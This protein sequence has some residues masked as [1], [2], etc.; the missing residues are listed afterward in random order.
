MTTSHWFK[1][2][3]HELGT[4]ECRDY[5]LNHVVGRIVLDDDQGPVAFPVNYALDGNDIVIAV[6]ADGEIARHATGHPVAFEIDDIDPANEA[7]WSVVVRGVAE[8]AADLPQDP[9]GRPYPWAEGNR[10]H[11]LRIRPQSVSGRQL[12]P[13]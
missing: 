10:S 12:I 7:G 1:A 11:L 6:S 8:Q 3:V 2:H 4:G 9:D 13:A 5:L